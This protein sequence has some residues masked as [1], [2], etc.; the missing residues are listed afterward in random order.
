M[1]LSRLRS[2]NPTVV[3]EYVEKKFKS[4]KGLRYTRSGRIK[5]VD[6]YYVAA[7]G[8]PHGQDV[9]Q[10]V[11]QTVFG[12]LYDDED[13]VRRADKAVKK[14]PEKVKVESSAWL[15]EQTDAQ[16][17]LENALATL[18][19]WKSPLVKEYEGGEEFFAKLRTLVSTVDKTICDT[20]QFKSEFAAD[21]RAEITSS[22]AMTKEEVSA[23]FDL[24]V[25]FQQ[26]AS[27]TFETRSLD[28]GAIN[29]KL[30]QSFKAGAWAN[31]EA[32]ARMTQAGFTAEAQAAIAIGAQ[33][34]LEGELKWTKG[35]GALVLSGD[36]EIF[37][38]AEAHGEL[39]I[40]GNALEGLELAIAAG[41]FAGFKASVSGAFAFEYGGNKIASVAASAGVTFGAGGEFSAKLSAPIFGPTTFAIDANVAVGL[42]V[43]TDIEVA[44]NFNEAALAAS[45]S[46]RQVVYW[47][48]MAKGWDSSLMEQDARNLFYLK[49]AIARLEAELADMT[50]KIDSFNA[51]PMEE[52][53]L[54][55]G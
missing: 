22:V 52:R 29:A 40:K 21:C 16:E 41:A 19:R 27:C 23:A 18:K 13:A 17:D 11:Y 14:K 25:G 36:G 26:N 38:G 28:W 12:E 49:K 33:F 3:Q 50:A 46:F 30:E 5:K 2:K 15:D 8:S 55:M 53:S 4:F 47:R 34:S 7:A 37:L 54:L 35:K 9:I 20:T 24:M 6:A 48:T 42:G 31:G 32:K 39:K 10:S 51:V 44:I 1:D 45:Q 43:N